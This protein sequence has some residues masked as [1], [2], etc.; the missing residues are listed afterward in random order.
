MIKLN[1]FFLNI[2][3][4]F[5]R[6]ILLLVVSFKFWGLKL[7]KVYKYFIRNILDINIKFINCY[8]NVFFVLV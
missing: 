1:L 8:R 6:V 4:L 3:R 7:A 5:I 2:L